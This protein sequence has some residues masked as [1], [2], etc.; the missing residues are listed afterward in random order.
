MLPDENTD[1]GPRLS[2]GVPG[3]WVVLGM[4]AFAI[5][6][7]G[8][9]WTYTKLHNAPFIPLRRALAEEFTRAAAPRVEG[10][11]HRNG[12][13]ILRVIVK[14]EFNLNEKSPL[15]IRSETVIFNVNVCVGMS[16]PGTLTL[17][18]VMKMLVA[19]TPPT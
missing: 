11:R 4:F 8:M 9:L 5:V 2:P 18:C 3:H 6:L 13:M 10:G 15:S 17:F 12:P 1:S 19:S 14:V 16:G 7:T